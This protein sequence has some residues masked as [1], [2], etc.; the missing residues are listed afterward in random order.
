ME[1]RS[2]IRPGLSRVPLAC[3]RGAVTV[4]Y[5]VAVAAL[6]CVWA[7]LGV[8][9]GRAE[10]VSV[11]DGSGNYGYCTVRVDPSPGVRYW[12]I[13]CN[14]QTGLDLSGGGAGVS[15][16]LIR[17][18]ANTSTAC[19]RSSAVT[20]EYESSTGQFECEDGGVTLDGY[21]YTGCSTTQAYQTVVDLTSGSPDP[22]RVGCES[23]DE[24]DGNPV[25]PE[26]WPSGSEPGS[27]GHGWG[28]GDEDRGA[29]D[30][31]VP[32]GWSVLNPVEWFY[33]VQ[34]VLVWA[35]V[36][37]TSFSDEWDSFAAA[38]DAAWPLGPITWAVSVPVAAIDSLVDGTASGVPLDCDWGPA[39]PLGTGGVHVPMGPGCADEFDS[40]RSYSL[41]LSRALLI[42]G[43]A[44]VLFRLAGWAM[45]TS[46]APGL[47]GGE[48]S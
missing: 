3:R 11:P 9:V 4:L 40:V 27:D 7:A 36:P 33:A 6:L 19:Y 12:R 37:T 16:R 44:I 10:E 38:L 31:C 34:C 39:L 13:R 47:G 43:T 2:A 14:L 15:V 26:D 46:S 35:F 20:F 42:V 28:T 22:R 25:W 5:G 24:G 23:V 29:L 32:S 48:E 17:N 21:T 45:G 18:G 30:A 1:V 8:R 41:I